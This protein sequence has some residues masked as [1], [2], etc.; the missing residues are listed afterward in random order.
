MGSYINFEHKKDDFEYI[1]ST[2]NMKKNTLIIYFPDKNE[3]IYDFFFKY[4]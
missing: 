1:L 3:T 2:P 4:E